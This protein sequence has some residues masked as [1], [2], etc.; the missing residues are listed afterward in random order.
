MEQGKKVFW[1][2]FFFY[3]GQSIY[4]TYGNPYLHSAGFS[5]STIGFLQAGATFLLLFVQPLWAKAFDRADNKA[6]ILCLL[7]AGTT[8]V[9]AGYG[10]YGAKPWLMLCTVGFA[11][12]FYPAMPVI[13][14]FAASVERQTRF[15]R[16]R[17]GGTLG[18]AFAAL[19][20]GVLLARDGEKQG[21]S[22]LLFVGMA[23]LFAAA[24]WSARRLSK[25]QRP[26]EAPKCG[27]AKSQRGYRELFHNKR[28]MSLVILNA[29]YYMSFSVFGQYYPIYYTKELNAGMSLLG[30]L[31][32][33]AAL[34]E[35]PFFWYADRFIKRFG[36]YRAMLFSSVC[37]IARWFLLAW[38]KNPY[39]A[40]AVN[41]LNGGGYL[42]FFCCAVTEI[43]RI[44]PREQQGGAQSFYALAATV[45]SK[46]VF[47]PL[48][49]MIADKSGV[50]TALWIGGGIMALGTG[51]FILLFWRGAGA[52]KE[53][54]ILRK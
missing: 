38:V 31:S 21:C 2:Y 5:K 41:L 30:L 17:V 40:I 11:L 46:L 22:P 14:S 32:F 9:S 19:V 26:E 45:L 15:G 7:L 12:F 23:L 43:K 51:I 13:D 4:N 27:R 3:A 54:L 20:M 18:Y 42:G 33:L 16:L 24:A 35:A 48:S 6:K 8:V 49:G 25:Q 52:K 10:L 34:S 50:P 44:V 1:L 29:A 28:Y 36:F 39:W 53:T 47:S 37:C